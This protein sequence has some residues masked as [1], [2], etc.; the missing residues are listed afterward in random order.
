MS[1]TFD[2]TVLHWGE[3]DRNAGERNGGKRN[4]EA[5]D[6]FIDWVGA[7]SHSFFIQTCGHT[8]RR[9][10]R[11]EHVSD[12]CPEGV[13]YDCR[14]ITA[15]FIAQPSD[16]AVDERTVPEMRTIANAV[17]VP[18]FVVTHHPFDYEYDFPVRIDR[19]VKGRRVE[20][21]GANWHE[22]TDA[23]RREQFHHEDSMSASGRTGGRNHP[24]CNSRRVQ[25]LE[26]VTGGTPGK[27][28][29][30]LSRVIREI[31]GV[32]HIDIDAAVICEDCGKPYCMVEGTSDGLGA[33]EAV[34]K[35]GFMTRGIA[36][37]LRAKTMMIHHQIG[38][39]DLES[40]IRVKLFRGTNP[41]PE[42]N[43]VGDWDLAA[44]ALESA[45]DYHRRFVCRT[46]R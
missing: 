16:V 36:A 31:P 8:A 15:I 11:G 27:V 6:S 37:K 33:R 28:D 29:L 5:M 10:H 34:K 35:A 20:H 46:R 43:K 26:T 9:E 40:E 39:V 38:D 7:R 1:K 30:T 32:R 2:P 45:H 24:D 18:L 17:G 41:E 23:L 14:D 22:V 13:T 21:V 42:R 44:S 19:Y 4:E 25:W 12:V 3:S